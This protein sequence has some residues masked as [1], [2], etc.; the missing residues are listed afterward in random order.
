VGEG[1]D[2]DRTVPQD[3]LWAL[4]DGA[5]HWAGGSFAD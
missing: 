2:A 5:Y 1:R 3:G 4:V